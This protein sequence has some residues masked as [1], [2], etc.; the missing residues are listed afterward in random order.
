METYKWQL[1]YYWDNEKGFIVNPERLEEIRV[2][3]WNGKLPETR[4]EIEN[5]ASEIFLEFFPRDVMNLISI[6][7]NIEVLIASGALGKISV[8]YPKS[9][10]VE[11]IYL[12]YEEFLEQYIKAN[13]R[14]SD[15]Y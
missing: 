9:P 14:E 12:S 15:G 5:L 1:A 10:Y 11:V 6:K 3:R 13:L 4:D 2:M 7:E 8:N